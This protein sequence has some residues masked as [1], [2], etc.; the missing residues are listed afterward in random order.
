MSLGV[1]QFI[2]KPQDPQELMR[3]INEV[4]DPNYV[5]KVVLEK[6]LGVEM[7]I[8]RKYNE[9]LFKKLEKK[10]IDLEIANQEL[11]NSEERYRLSFE[12]ATD[13]IFMLD[14]DLNIMS[15]SPSI[16]SIVG[17]NPQDFVK[18]HLSNFKTILTTETF[19]DIISDFN[20][21]IDERIVLSQHINLLQRTDH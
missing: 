11:R 19:N 7:K 18:K 10:M 1:D 8:F 20:K 15:L 3:I 5:T 4:L 9:I 6:P 21:V 2:L 17:Y 14:R 12:N 16:K 13:M